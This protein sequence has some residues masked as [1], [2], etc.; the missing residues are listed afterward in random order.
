MELNDV[1][2][3]DAECYSLRYPHTRSPE[4]EGAIPAGERH[5]AGAG[6]SLCVNEDWD[7]PRNRPRTCANCVRHQNWE[8]YYKDRRIT[9][10]VV[11]EHSDGGAQIL[12]G[13]A[14]DDWLSIVASQ[15]A[16]AHAHGMGCPPLPWV[17]LTAAEYAER[18]GKK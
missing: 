14:A 2:D 13:D 5:C 4:C 12:E 3:R 1:W 16:L 8:W 18:K 7:D 9:T 17:R 15:G 11:I 10:R 6:E